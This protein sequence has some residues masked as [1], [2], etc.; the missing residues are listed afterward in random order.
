VAPV[1]GAAAAGAFAKPLRGS[2]S[3]TR[4]GD[5]DELE[6][7]VIQLEPIDEVSPIGMD[8]V[9]MPANCLNEGASLHNDELASES[10]LMV[11]EYIPEPPCPG[12]D[13]D[14]VGAPVC[15]PSVLV[16]RI[17]GWEQLVT[18]PSPLEE[19][20]ALTIPLQKGGV[21]D[22][23][24]ADVQPTPVM[25]ARPQAVRVAVSLAELELSVARRRRRVG[26]GIGL[27][28]S[29]S[30]APNLNFPSAF[31]LAS[32]RDGSQAG[33]ASLE[34]VAKFAT[35][36]FED[37]NAGRHSTDTADLRFDKE[38][39][40]QMR[41]IGQFNLGFII[42]SLRA[43]GGDDGEQGLAND[44]DRADA[45][46]GGIQ[47]FII[48][49]HASDEKFRFEALNRESRI[50]RQPL[51]SPHHLQL[52]P[53]QEQLVEAHLEV[54]RLN[55]FEVRRDDTRPPGRRLRLTALPTCQ[56]L[57]FGERDI[58]DLLHTL[59]EAE[60]DQATPNTTDASAKGA[61]GLLDLAGHRALWSATSV[62]RPSKVWQLLACRACRGALMIG[63]ALRISEMER[64]LSNLS[65]LQHPW[66]CPHGR[67][68]MRHLVDAGAAWRGPPAS[69]PLAR[70]LSVSPAPEGAC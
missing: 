62:P 44:C 54:F 37:T 65:T 20:Q 41:V 32:L 14:S 38:C 28:S 50:D 21:S 22:A 13:T 17:P 68:T 64:V 10:F 23:T 52:A 8:V 33:S 1:A 27:G 46:A 60:T 5:N 67:P 59:E 69:L 55:G 4:L 34:E 53:A 39:F 35:D 18:V 70:L 25:M 49:Q 36:N 24:V 61:G 40:S 9:E 43:R 58:Y 12:G 63:K 31:S 56:G 30:L 48:D 19:N 3:P 15:D 11:E 45:S 16:E 42:A 66:N 47:L 6:L 26:G 2:P 7:S 57:V 29:K 51:V